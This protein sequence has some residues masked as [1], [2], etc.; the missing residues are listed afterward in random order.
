MLE[1]SDQAHRCLIGINR[2]LMVIAGAL[3]DQARREPGGKSAPGVTNKLK[4]AD[5]ADWTLADLPDTFGEP[6][7]RQQQGADDAPIGDHPVF[8]RHRERVA[9]R[10]R[11]AH[12]VPGDTGEA[13]LR[14][15]YITAR[16]GNL[17]ADVEPIVEM[18]GALSLQPGNLAGESSLLDQ[19]AV[20]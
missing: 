6:D 18:R 13:V 7:L 4:A 11:K 5:C 16:I 8:Q 2:K 10:G 3:Q 9:T 1:T 15:R 17:P 20:A 14:C 19:P 12:K